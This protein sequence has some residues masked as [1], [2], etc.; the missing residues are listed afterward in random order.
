MIDRESE[1]SLKSYWEDLQ[2]F[3]QMDYRNNFLM[4]FK[5]MSAYH[6]YYSMISPDQIIKDRVFL[7]YFESVLGPKM[8]IERMK[9]EGIDNLRCEPE[10]DFKKRLEE[11]RARHERNI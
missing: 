11:L 1:R 8:M 4:S 6:D 2:H 10:D 9:Y 7:R 3:E 5:P